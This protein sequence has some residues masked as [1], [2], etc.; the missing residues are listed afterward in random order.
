[1]LNR[2][3]INR[4]ERRSQARRVVIS[5]GRGSRAARSGAE[6]ATEGT[7]HDSPLRVRCRQPGR[8]PRASASSVVAWGGV[9]GPDVTG[10]R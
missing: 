2:I 1:M 10:S 7:D 8:R 9:A 4:L 5:G 6:L 3:L